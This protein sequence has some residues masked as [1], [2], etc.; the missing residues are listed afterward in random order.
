MSSRGDV[1]AESDAAV[2]GVAV[3]DTEVESL[4]KSVTKKE[5]SAMKTEE[6]VIIVMR[7]R[8]WRMRSAKKIL[9]MGAAL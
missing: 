9:E 7:A 2:V 6:S 1:G 8:S 3:A 4:L 5:K